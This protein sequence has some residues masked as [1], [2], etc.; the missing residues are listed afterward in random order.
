MLF[1]IGCLFSQAKDKKEIKKKHGKLKKQESHHGAI[2]QG[3]EQM[4]LHRVKTRPSAEEKD[5]LD[6]EEQENLQ[7]LKEKVHIITS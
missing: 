2:L 3:S 1:L 6:E 7:K 4:Q 5:S